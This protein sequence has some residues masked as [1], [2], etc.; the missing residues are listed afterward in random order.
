MLKNSLV[1]ALAFAITSTNSGCGSGIESQIPQKRDFFKES[2]LEK[3]VNLNLKLDL[4]N[5][6]GFSKKNVNIDDPRISGLTISAKGYRDGTLQS[7]LYVSK[8]I[9]TNGTEPISTSLQV[10]PNAYYTIDI[11]T[12]SSDGRILGK[13][14]TAERVAEGDTELKFNHARMLLAETLSIYG[15]SL[16]N[17]LETIKNL[18][19]YDEDTNTYDENKI[20][21]ALLD[22]N[23]VNNC[24]SGFAS[25][26]SQQEIDSLKTNVRY[27]NII[28]S[29]LQDANGKSIPNR[30]KS[31][32]IPISAISIDINSEK[33]N[34]TSGNRIEITGVSEIGRGIV[35]LRGGRTTWRC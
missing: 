28:L 33:A 34:I 7:N 6:G 26:K 13:I 22:T 1:I 2:K 31:E 12:F 29:N 14:S 20:E 18:T 15:G 10:S 27:A 30:R 8:S 19:G 24:A 3:N 11:T 5:L 16:D 25:C 23:I 32:D 35:H 9:N 4:D 21:P 17:L